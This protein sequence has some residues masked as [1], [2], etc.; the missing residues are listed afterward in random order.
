MD[1]DPFG[2]SNAPASFQRFMESCLG[3]LRDEVCIPYWDDIIVFLSP[4]F[5]DH[6]THLRKVL[7]RLKEHGVKLKPRNVHCS[8]EKYCS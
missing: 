1:S 2:L 6:I 8:D 3:D 7:R 4:T 5:E